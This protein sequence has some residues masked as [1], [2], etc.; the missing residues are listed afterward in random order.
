MNPGAMGVLVPMLGILVGGAI[1]ITRMITGHL[2][3]TRGASQ[4]EMEEMRGE[5]RALTANVQHV[6]ETLA[7]MT[8]MLNDSQDRRLPPT[9]DDA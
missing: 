9:R 4:R 2:A 6:Q 5:L 7:D 8:L 1:V 3:S